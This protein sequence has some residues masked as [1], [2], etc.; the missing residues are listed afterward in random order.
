MFQWAFKRGRSYVEFQGERS[1][2]EGHNTIFMIW[3]VQTA[4][5]EQQAYDYL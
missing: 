1:R 3:I 2:E 4:R 5:V